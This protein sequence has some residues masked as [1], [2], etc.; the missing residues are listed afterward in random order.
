MI[1][2]MPLI[3]YDFVI[4]SKLKGL[5]HGIPTLLERASV[6]I[7]FTSSNCFNPP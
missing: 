5:F 3:V 1:D 6:R 4:Q 7:K 2:E